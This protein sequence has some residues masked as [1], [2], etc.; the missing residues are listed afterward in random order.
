MKLQ[1][2]IDLVKQDLFTRFPNCHYTVRI[3]LWDDNTYMVECRHGDD[4]KL[5]ISKYYDNK[6]TYEEI[7]IKGRHNG[8]MK[9]EKGT[10][11]FPIQYADHKSN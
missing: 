7:D 8:M 3:L 10:E 6:L 11:Y 2:K 4:E 5:Y 1:E 9:D